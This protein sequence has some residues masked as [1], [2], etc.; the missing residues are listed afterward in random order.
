VQL[1]IARPFAPRWNVGIFY[2][3]REPASTF[4]P[5]I[6]ELVPYFSFQISDSWSFTGLTAFGFTQASATAAVLGQISYSW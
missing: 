5:E 6:H 2:E 1:G 4:S 3:Y